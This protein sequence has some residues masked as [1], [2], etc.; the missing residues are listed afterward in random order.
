MFGRGQ[1]V[2]QLVDVLAKAAALCLQT[3]PVDGQLGRAGLLLLQTLRDA[4]KLSL[5]LTTGLLQLNTVLL[6]RLGSL[7]LLGGSQRQCRW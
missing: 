3:L 4:G 1:G 5:Q 6:R 7:L 2:V